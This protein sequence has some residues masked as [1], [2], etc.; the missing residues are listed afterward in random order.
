MT[1]DATL[2]RRLRDVFARSAAEAPVH[3][4]AAGERPLLGVG[5]TDRSD[6]RR[7]PR[8]ALLVGAAAAAVALLVALRE[9]RHDATPAFRPEGTEVPLTQVAPHDPGVP[10]QPGSLVG[11]EIPGHPTVILYVTLSWQDGHVVEHRCTS[12]DGGAGCSPAW[13]WGSPDLS[14][15]STVDNRAGT[16]NLYTWANVPAGTAFVL[17]ESPTG[18]VWQRPVAGFVGFPITSEIEDE[19]L[20]AYDADGNVIDE[21]DYDVYFERLKASTPPG[22]W[23]TDPA[24]PEF[25]AYAT[26]DNL[27][28]TQ[29]S[30]MSE[31]TT[32][33]V[34]ACLAEDGA[35]WDGCVAATETVVDERFTAM[36]GEVVAYEVPVEED[37]ALDPG[38][39]ITTAPG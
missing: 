15:T 3:L 39:S 5:R 16:F 2:E 4:P 6:R 34:A 30:E 25:L 27:S 26:T 1:V 14:R 28:S 32:A 21:V 36:G 13:N 24:N 11:L 18:P 35:T 17:W 29:R 7:A 33:T 37:D 12:S 20:V 31:L 9:T 19:L 10:V 23:Q 38:V 8:A 22:G